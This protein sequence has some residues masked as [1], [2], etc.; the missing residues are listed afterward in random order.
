VIRL[1]TAFVSVL[2]LASPVSSAGAPAREPGQLS[3]SVSVVV[4]ELQD[5]R[6][7]RGGLCLFGANGSQGTRLTAPKFDE[8]PSWSPNG[9]K[10]AFSRDDAIYVQDDRGRSRL[11]ADPGNHNGHPDWSHDGRRIAFDAG[12]SAF[13]IYSV[14]P[15]GSDVEPLTSPGFQV[16]DENPAWSPSGDAIAFGEIRSGALTDLFLIDP[17][18][19]NR[20]LLAL[21]GWD[22]SWSPDGKWLVFVRYTLGY[23]AADLMIIG[24]DGSGE[25]P[26]TATRELETAPAWSPD[27]EW[28]A[29]ETGGPPSGGEDIAVVRPD[30]SDYHVLRGSSLRET[31]PAWRPQASRRPGR[32]RPC[33]IRARRGGVVRGTAQGDLILGSEGR[34]SIFGRGGN[35]LVD[36]GGGADRLVGGHGKDILS[37]GS[38]RDYLVGGP[39]NDRLYADDGERDVAIGDGGYDTAYVDS[40]DRLRSVEKIYRSP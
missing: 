25:R 29:F 23:S 37:G 4:T 33:F 20:R 38:G 28:I 21:N 15:D 11:I 34:D 9:R 3:Y 26:L 14:R 40:L 35:D 7:V 16:F 8:S 17:D 1:A 27:G 5:T 22:P 18:G 31:D 36:G 19:G 12:A 2:V 24:A 30:G 32:Q 6:L 13:A 39:G 10:L